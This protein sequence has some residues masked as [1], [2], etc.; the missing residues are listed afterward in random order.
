M[1]KSL[2]KEIKEYQSFSTAKAVHLCSTPPYYRLTF[3]WITPF[4][5]SSFTG[6]AFSF[7]SFLSRLSYCPY[8]RCSPSCQPLLL[9]SFLKIQRVDFAL[10]TLAVICHMLE[11]APLQLL[12]FFWGLNAQ[13][14]WGRFLIFINMLVHRAFRVVYY[15]VCPSSSSRRLC[16]H[17]AGNWCILFLFLIPIIA[18]LLLLLYVLHRLLDGYI[19]LFTFMISCFH[20]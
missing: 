10:Q 17:F 19:Y 6:L 9:E 1:R 20:V 13:R 18:L 5:G 3:Q 16:D 2:S 11:L 8:N 12:G 7:V 14:G 4:I 15:L